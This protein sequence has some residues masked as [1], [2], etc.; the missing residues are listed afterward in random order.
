[1]APLN[2]VKYA[3]G[4]VAD[5]AKTVVHEM[6]ILD[7]DFS[8]LYCYALITCICLCISVYEVFTF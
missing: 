5:N 8:D 4:H 7:V 3:A 6:H 2:I 1:M